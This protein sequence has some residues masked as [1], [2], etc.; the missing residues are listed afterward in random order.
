MR[1]SAW[2]LLFVLFI[3][4][5]G[6]IDIRP[7]WQGHVTAERFIMLMLIG[8]LFC[9]AYPRRWLTVL[10]LL[11]CATALF[12]LLQRITPDRHG[13]VRDFIVKS[14]GATAGVILGKVLLFLRASIK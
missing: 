8:T 5:I 2:I 7:H 14:A 4:T 1:L 10:V 11:I 6:P 9:L 12:E 13:E 3:V